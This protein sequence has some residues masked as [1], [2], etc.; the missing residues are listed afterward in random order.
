MDILSPETPRTSSGTSKTPSS[1]SSCGTNPNKDIPVIPHTDTISVSLPPFP[2]K[3][4]VNVRSYYVEITNPIGAKITGKLVELPDNLIIVHF[5]TTHTGRYKIYVFHDSGIPVFSD[6]V[7]YFVKA[8]DQMK[9]KESIL[10]PSFLGGFPE[11]DCML[12][13][14][15]VQNR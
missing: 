5:T 11:E 12:N 10:P 13:F 4:A 9:V 1:G 14:T 15:M 2:G 6:P 8:P 7:V 3:A